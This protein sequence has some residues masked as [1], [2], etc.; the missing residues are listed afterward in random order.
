MQTLI[1]E[2]T[3]DFT[4]TDSLMSNHTLSEV[5]NSRQSYLTWLLKSSI[6]SASIC[7]CFLSKSMIIPYSPWLSK[8]NLYILLFVLLVINLLTIYTW[9]MSVWWINNPPSICCT[10]NAY[11]STPVAIFSVSAFPTSPTSGLSHIHLFRLS[12]DSHPQNMETKEE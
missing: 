11:T 8:K 6:K 10:S 4:L 3:T 12:N 7:L 5:V 9:S 2:E 1:I